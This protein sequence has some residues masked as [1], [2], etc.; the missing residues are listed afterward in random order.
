MTAAAPSQAI[1]FYERHPIS[2]A[3]ILA[4]LE[5]NADLSTD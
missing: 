3:Q 4:R 5:L 2:A 1:S